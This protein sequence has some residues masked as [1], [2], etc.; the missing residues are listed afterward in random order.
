MLT[1][2]SIHI[3]AP[4]VPSAIGD[5]AG[6][7]SARPQ[8]PY[9]VLRSLP[10]DATPAQ[11]DSAI[12]VW[13]QPGEIHYSERPDTL[14]L[15]GH[16]VGRN[17]KDVNLPQYYRES[18]FSNDTLLHPELEAGRYGVAGDPV[19]YAIG[20][21]NVI[22]CIL[23]ACFITAMPAMSVCRNFIAHQVKSLF[24][25]TKTDHEHPA[26][27]SEIKALLLLAFQ[28]VILLSLL[29]FFYTRNY[30]ADTFI[31]S[32]DYMVIALIMAGFLAYFLI[33][34]PVYSF[35]NLTFFNSKSRFI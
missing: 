35:V 4:A 16:G 25:F 12:Q 31:L 26:T 8:T 32:D 21:D 11:Q 18:F 7:I 33:K 15:P 10:K 9:Q 29:Y 23:I 28:T 27:S 22:S 30:L 5:T 1:T 17:L 19:A 14:H 24:Y 34:P 2:D 13:F 3:E 6:R 20:H